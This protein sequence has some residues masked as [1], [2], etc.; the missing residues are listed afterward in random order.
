MVIVSIKRKM[1]IRYIQNRILL[2]AIFFLCTR[3]FLVYSKS[4]GG[5]MEKDVEKHFNEFYNKLVFLDR[6]LG[7]EEKTFKR[8]NYFTV[9]NGILSIVNE[10]YEKDE[11]IYIR[12]KGLV[13]TFVYGGLFNKKHKSLEIYIS[14]DP[15]Y[16]GND[17]GSIKDLLLLVDEFIEN[18]YKEF[19]EKINKIIYGTDNSKNKRVK[20]HTSNILNK[21]YIRV[22]K[23]KDAVVKDEDIDKIKTYPNLRELSINN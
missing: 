20:Y 17:T 21:D 23:I 3:N 10:E 16:K 4:Q 8:D 11:E 18:N 1:A 19:D 12:D 2:F 14:K 9:D 5:F 6:K 15:Y 7:G 13:L 22:I